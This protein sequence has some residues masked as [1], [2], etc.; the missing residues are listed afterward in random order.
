MPTCWLSAGGAY[1]C[2]SSVPSLAEIVTSKET[3]VAVVPKVGKVQRIHL[4][5]VSAAGADGSPCNSAQVT[6]LTPSG[7]QM[8]KRL[9]KTVSSSLASVTVCGAE[10]E[11]AAASVK[12]G[13]NAFNKNASSI[14]IFKF[15]C[16]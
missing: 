15:L 3:R 9:F 12:E 1:W 8:I 6:H 7:V 2:F 14:N 11:G 4:G 16:N 13:I 10:K 5:G